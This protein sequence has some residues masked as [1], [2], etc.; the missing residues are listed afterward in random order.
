M[1]ARAA[2]TPQKPEERKG[3]QAGGDK[4]LGRDDD[5]SFL[6]MEN[7]LNRIY[8]ELRNMG[9]SPQERALNYAATNAFVPG[10][11]VERAAIR[12]L[13]LDEIEVEQS[14]I[15]RKDSDCWDVKLIF[16]DSKNILASRYLSR[17]T[18]DVSDVV[19]VIVG[20][21]REWNIR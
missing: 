15:C 6:Q 12:H 11:V 3:K 21:V 19:P 18:V 5:E 7:F 14:P 20:T 1:R 2:T 9:A 10:T 17:F 16:F 13:L 8:F 4:K